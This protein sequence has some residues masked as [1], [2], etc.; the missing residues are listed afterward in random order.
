MLAIEITPDGSISRKIAALIDQNTRVKDQA[1]RAVRE[2]ALS[3]VAYATNLVPWATGALA[4]SIAKPTFLYSGMAAIIGSYLPYAARQEYDATLK[5]TYRPQPRFR[6]VSTKMGKAG[7]VIQG[8]QQ[9]NPNATWGFLRKALAKEK[10]AFIEKLQRIA[11]QF[12]EGW[13]A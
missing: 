6:Q 9:I 1:S 4:R 2:S 7:S 12:G 13:T 3:V 5:H 11:D 8:T 10:P